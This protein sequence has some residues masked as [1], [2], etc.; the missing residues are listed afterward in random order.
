MKGAIAELCARTISTPRRKRLTNMGI[1]HHLLI[2]QKNDSKSPT[3]PKRLAAV[4]AAFKAPMVILL[5]LYLIAVTT[6]VRASPICRCRLGPGSGA[7][8]VPESQDI[9]VPLFDFLDDV[10]KG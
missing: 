6:E 3:V 4:R 7:G 5:T 9:R 8:T 1:S 10:S 2:L